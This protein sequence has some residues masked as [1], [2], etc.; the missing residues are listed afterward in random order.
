MNTPNQRWY[1]PVQ[2]IKNTINN[3][4]QKQKYLFGIFIILLIIG[5][6]G[7][8]ATLYRSTTIIVPTY[9][10]S[11]VEGIVGSPRF[12]NPVLA[13][14]N[15][16]KDITEIVYAG[17]MTYREDGTYIPELAEEYTVSE[18]G[19][20]Y[21]FTLKKDIKFHDGKPL[22]AH[23]VVF[24][25][26]L[27]QN[28]AVKSP[29]RPEWTGVTA[30]VLDDYTVQF[31]LETPYAGFLR[32]ATLG[33]MPKHLFE[34]LAPNQ[35]IF[36]E[37]NINAVGAGPFKIKKVI[38]DSIGIPKKLLLRRNNTYTLGKPFLKKITFQFYT[39]LELA[40]KSLQKKSIDGL[41]SVATKDVPL[42]QNKKYT[43]QHGALSQVFALFLNQNRQDIFLDTEVRKAIDIAIPKEAI[44]K[45]IFSDYGTTLCGPIPPSMPGYIPCNET[46][47]HKTGQERINRASEILK[48][49][50]WKRNNEGLLTK[51][52]TVLEFKVAL[53][54]NSELKETAAMIE[55]TLSDIGINMKQQIFEPGNFDQDIIRPRSYEALLFGQIYEHDT[56]SSAF[57]HSSGQT[58]PGFNIGLYANAK[59]D[60]LLKE[61]LQKDSL[62][63]RKN[64][65]SD[66]NNIFSQDI[67]AIFLYTPN[68][69]YITE[70]NVILPIQK[71]IIKPHHRFASIHTWYRYTNRVWESFTK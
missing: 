52:G 10:G 63:E 68:F 30:T 24:T 55:T 43:I 64:L 27:A 53:P 28:S 1:T 12:I 62:P 18:D 21:N 16:D 51:N 40:Q 46:I 56:D 7:T 19:M 38:K 39:S 70:T 54:N 49:N 37:Y 66:L 36:S 42:F 33:I 47:S 13:S 17:L 67:P 9:G 60:K 20:I 35:I 14:S 11:F 3:F 25:V 44:I 23:D 32:T 15:P 50:G 59:A 57:W 2:V 29:L 26:Q 71:A 65:Y 41:H 61:T 69:I 31:I 45:R 22:T 34:N 48:S 58:D 4:T 5:C 6:I 8:T